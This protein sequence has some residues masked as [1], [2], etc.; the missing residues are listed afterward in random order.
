MKLSMQHLQ[1]YQQLA[2]LLWKYGRADVVVG[3]GR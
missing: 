3:I 1:R 2:R